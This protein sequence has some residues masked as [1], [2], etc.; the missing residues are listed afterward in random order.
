MPPSEEGGGCLHKGFEQADGGRDTPSMCE[1]TLYRQWQKQMT[2][3]SLRARLHLGANSRL[4][5]SLP[6]SSPLYPKRL[7][8]SLLRGSRGG[9][10]A[11]R[12]VCL[13]ER[14]EGAEKCAQF[15]LQRTGSR[16]VR[17]VRLAENREPRA[18]PRRAQI[19]RGGT[20]PSKCA[21]TRGTPKHF[22]KGRNISHAQS[23]YFTAPKARFHTAAKLPYITAARRDAYSLLQPFGT[24][25]SL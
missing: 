11:S 9:S 18:L 10:A 7:D 20:T 21:A 23:A 3:F 12:R 19:C 14:T 24:K 16:E 15:A 17:S 1:N 13:A 6:Q 8:S 5:L 25:K 2:A 22:A 4:A